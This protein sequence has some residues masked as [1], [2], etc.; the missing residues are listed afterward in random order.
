MKAIPRSRG[1]GKA[2]RIRSGTQGFKSKRERAGKKRKS[3][4]FL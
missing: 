4:Y 2:K 3:Y 1:E